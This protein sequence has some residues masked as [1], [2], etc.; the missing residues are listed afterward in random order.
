MDR[1]RAIDSLM[2]LTNV[3][4]EGLTLFVMGCLAFTELTNKARRRRRSRRPKG[5]HKT[6]R[7]KTGDKDYRRRRLLL[8][9]RFALISHS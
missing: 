4:E 2:L 1:L 5:I 3:D 6:K 8:S 9:S 7:G